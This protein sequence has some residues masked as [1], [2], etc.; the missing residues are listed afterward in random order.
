MNAVLNTTIKICTAEGYEF[1]HAIVILLLKVQWF[2][3]YD[4]MV[5]L[6]KRNTAEAKELQA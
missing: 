6:V 3:D 4:R 2:E 1:I 5:A